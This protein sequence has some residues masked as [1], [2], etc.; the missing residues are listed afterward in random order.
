MND[1]ALSNE[2]FHFA[3][4]SQHKWR[5]PEICYVMSRNEI[6]WMCISCGKFTVGG[7][8]LKTN[9]ERGSVG[10]YF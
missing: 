9:Y 7:I 4:A 5:K 2:Y 6:N 3:D 10:E 8:L 1:S